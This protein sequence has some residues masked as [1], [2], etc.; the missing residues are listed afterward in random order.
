MCKILAFTDTKRLNL[1]KCVND[2]GNT[3][4]KL[5]KDGFGYAVQGKNGVFGEKTI[6][7]HFRTRLNAK[8]MVTLPIVKVQYSKFG[9]PSALTGP[10][11]FHGR[12]STNA[13]GLINTHP[14][15]RPDEKGIW[16]LIHNGVVTDHGPAYSKLTDNDSE[17]VL[18]RLMQGINQVETQLTGYYAFTC[19]D[20]NGFLHV[21]RDRI[22]PLYM[23]WSAIYDTFIIATT[24]SLL[25]KISKM[26]N[27]KIG[28][29]DE[30]EDD[31]YMV[32]NGNE[33][34]HSQSIKSRGWTKRE[35]QHSM[36]SLGVNLGG[37]EV[38]VQSSTNH[39]ISKS[40]ADWQSDSQWDEAIKNITS[41]SEEQTVD[42]KEVAYYE[43]L[44]EIEN[45]DSSY[46]IT[47]ADDNYIQVHEFLKLDYISK[48]M[49]TIIRP[50]GTLLDSSG[51]L[52]L[53]S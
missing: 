34:I 2:I 27:A 29:I 8:N 40:E 35:S 4:L 32:F 5:E 19:I 53:S 1:K 3:L 21:G 12:T 9:Q 24:E 52:K 16:H 25:L 17:D 33:L 28:P 51:E 6:A 50:D 49:C 39:S 45:M 18:H 43:Y 26:L 47:D 44:K 42:D 37:G 41:A 48:E 20:S 13:D 10:G 15:Q 46:T 36:S 38:M 23:A 31:V 22:A 14:M 11:I 7:P 30:I